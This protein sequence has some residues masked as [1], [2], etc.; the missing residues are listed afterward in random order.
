MILTIQPVTFLRLFRQWKN[1][2]TSMQ[3]SFLRVV[4]AEIMAKSEVAGN[5]VRLE[6]ETAYHI[7]ED[8]IKEYAESLNQVLEK[9]DQDWDI[10]TIRGST[11]EVD[12]SDEEEQPTL[13]DEGELGD[14]EKQGEDPAQD[15]NEGYNGGQE[16][17]E[18]EEDDEG[19]EEGH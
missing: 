15:R 7:D 14:L 5:K 12:T 19:E 17:G 9:T 1:L 6:K 2:P 10:D 16:D 4:R 18:E 11:T 8:E 13:I 3:E